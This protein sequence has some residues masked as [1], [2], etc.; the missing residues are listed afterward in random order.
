MS[1]AQAFLFVFAVGGSICA[2]TWFFTRKLV[3][4]SW[5]WRM[6]ICI[7]L[8]A[9]IAP[10]CFPFLARFVIW[11]AVLMLPMV[12][13]GEN[14]PALFVLLF[15]AVPILFAASLVFVIWSIIIHRSHRR[16]NHVV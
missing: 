2:V 9:T 12:F 1:T 16:E 3:Q 7:M 15:S 6:L 13:D 4:R 10:T 14:K 11:R 8:G 5:G